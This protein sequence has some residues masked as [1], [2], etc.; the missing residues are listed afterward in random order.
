MY[1]EQ[2]CKIYTNFRK[3]T[4]PKVHVITIK[5]Q[6]FHTL[7]DQPNMFQPVMSSSEVF[8]VA[9]IKDCIGN[10]LNVY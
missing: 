4:K 10:I 3:Q 9:L 6:L 8:F 5:I 2:K 1:T 7:L